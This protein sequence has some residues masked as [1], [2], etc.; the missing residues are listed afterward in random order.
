MDICLL[1]LIETFEETGLSR[2]EAIAEATLL[3]YQ[4]DNLIDP[5]AV[6]DEYCDCLLEEYTIESSSMDDCV[7]K[8]IR[9]EAHAH[10]EMPHKQII[11]IAFS[12]CRKK[13]GGGE[14]KARKESEGMPKPKACEQFGMD[15]VQCKEALAKQ[16]KI[17]GACYSGT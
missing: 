10:P 6:L 5:E 13:H 17:H 12:K 14:T 9:H 8:M 11:A 2:P 16:K 3:K 7:P 1:S 15:S 4:M